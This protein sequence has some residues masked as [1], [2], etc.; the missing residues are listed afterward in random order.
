MSTSPYIIEITQDNYQSA[1]IEQSQKVPVLVD[2]WASWC[3]PCQ[4]LMPVLAKLAE[5]YQGK[6][7]LAKINTEEQQALAGQFGIRSIPTIKLFKNG[8]AVDEFAG[9]LPESEIRRFLDKHIPRESDALVAQAE[10]LL[11]QGDSDAALKILEQAKLADADN[12][13]IDIALAQA[14]AAAGNTEQALE[15]TAQMPAEIQEKPQVRVLQGLLFFE[16]MLSG[17]PSETELQKRLEN[18]ASDSEARYLLAA[19]YVVN[20][21]YEDAIQL[22]LEL[23]RKDRNYGNDAARKSL[24]KIFDILGDDPLVPHYR[25]KMM[26]LIY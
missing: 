9:A 22:L 19:H 11:L 16:Q 23:M 7:I 5:Q 14:H 10:Q 2:F 12:S 6:F 15:I 26:S 4:M 13:N 18:D 24:L 21:R 3:Q 25:S 17:A 8:E 20:H 1:V